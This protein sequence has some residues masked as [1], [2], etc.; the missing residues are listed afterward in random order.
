MTGSW[1]FVCGP[2]GAGKDSVMAWARERLAGDARI[3]FARRL[4]TR[5]AGPGSDDD[6][7]SAATLQALREAGKIGFEWSAHGHAY[8]IAGHYA[9]DVDAGRVVV[10]NGSREHVAALPREPRLRSVVVTAP[11]HT[12]AQRLQARGRESA[13]A[14]AERIQRNLQLAQPQA[15]LVIPNTGP[16][17]QAG[18]QLQ[19]WLLALAHAQPAPLP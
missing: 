4:V 7:I 5:P 14:V 16:L 18:R 15:D 10:I 9:K 17:P 2:S 1:V 12:V 11:L 19:S 8:A 13:R 6:E 3:V